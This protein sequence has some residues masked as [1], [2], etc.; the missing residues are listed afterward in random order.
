M[1]ERQLQLMRKFFNVVLELGTEY[2]NDEN[3]KLELEKLHI[4]EDSVIDAYNKQTHIKG[5][6]DIK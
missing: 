3:F 2:Q 4:F 1:N 5:L 6:R